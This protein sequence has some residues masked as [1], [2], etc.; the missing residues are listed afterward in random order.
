MDLAEEVPA[1]VPIAVIL[2]VM[3]LSL[4]FYL[5]NYA[6]SS[7][8]LSMHRFAINALEKILL[9]KKGLLNKSMLNDYD[10]FEVIPSTYDMCVKVVNLENNSEEWDFCSGDY[11]LSVSSPVIISDGNEN[12]VGRITVKVRR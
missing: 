6:E 9:K 12:I 8:A 2:V 1:L 4:S 11:E 5:I 7:S 3:F 10:Y